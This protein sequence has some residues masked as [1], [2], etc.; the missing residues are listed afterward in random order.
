MDMDVNQPRQEGLT[1]QIEP[2]CIHGHLF[3]G[4]DRDYTVP[5]NENRMAQNGSATQTVENGGPA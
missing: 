4:Q 2:R 3:L 1:G 5:S